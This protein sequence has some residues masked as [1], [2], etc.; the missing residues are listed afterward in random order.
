M[1]RLT[2]TTVALATISCL[3]LPDHAKALP[4][5]SRALL[6]ATIIQFDAVSCQLPPW[7]AHGWVRNVPFLC[8]DP[9]YLWWPY[10]YYRG[11]GANYRYH[12]YWRNQLRDW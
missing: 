5:S 3:I 9:S 6:R 7:Y 1:R 8:Q 12:R 4:L 2:G 11:I 10:Y